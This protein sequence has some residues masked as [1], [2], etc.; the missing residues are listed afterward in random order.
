MST[1][2]D[3]SP[4]AARARLHKVFGIE[5]LRSMDECDA[6]GLSKWLDA[7]EDMGQQIGMFPKREAHEFRGFDGLA[8]RI[9]Q[10][11]SAEELECILLEMTRLLILWKGRRE[12]LRG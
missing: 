11:A 3:A 8:R 10:A 2:P 1:P 9:E 12:K 7:L 6:A 5:H 4:E